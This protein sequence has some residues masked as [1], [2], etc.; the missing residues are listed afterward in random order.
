MG[1]EN[2][3]LARA[4]IEIAQY[5]A[6]ANPSKFKAAP[7]LDMNTGSIVFHLRLRTGLIPTDAVMDPLPF[8]TYVID[9]AERANAPIDVDYAGFGVFEMLR[10]YIGLIAISAPE[11]ALGACHALG[12]IIGVEDLASRRIDPD[13][14]KHPIF[15]SH[16]K[17]RGIYEDILSWRKE[18]LGSAKGQGNKAVL[19]PNGE[20]RACEAVEHALPQ[21]K[22]MKKHYRESR[23]AWE[24][25]RKQHNQGSTAGEWDTYWKQ[26]DGPQEYGHLSP[27]VLALFCD[28][29]DIFI[30]CAHIAPIFNIETTTL[31]SKHKAWRLNRKSPKVRTQSA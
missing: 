9:L 4:A 1:K 3:S 6:I 15:L 18:I 29:S 20:E 21:I 28:H 7:V 30:A 16:A 13:L 22:E 8:A 14:R 12:P 11:A 23:K 25:N 10:R 2:E 19:S 24:Q 17:L 31:E 26:V 5:Y 27:D